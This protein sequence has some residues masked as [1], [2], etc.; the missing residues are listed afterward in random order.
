MVLPYYVKRNYL[1]A[2]PAIDILDVCQIPYCN[3]VYSVP[4]KLFLFVL[5]G[6]R[7]YIYADIFLLFT[8]SLMYVIL[9]FIYGG[10]NFINESPN[11]QINAFCPICN[12]WIEF[13]DS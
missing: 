9:L 5:L 8:F 2:P 3:S 13:I 10:I 7:V 4:Y 6:S 12:E 1:V 11:E